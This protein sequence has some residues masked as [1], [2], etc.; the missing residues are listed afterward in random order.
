MEVRS[1]ELAIRG[2][3]EDV[4]VDGVQSYEIGY[5]IRGIVNPG[6]GTAELAEQVNA[7]IRGYRERMRAG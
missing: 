4:E 1:A 3:D 7:A 2:G 6:T 5:R